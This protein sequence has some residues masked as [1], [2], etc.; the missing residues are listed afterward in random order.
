M[1]W[2]RTRALGAAILVG[3]A[4][5]F[6]LSW[7]KVIIVLSLCLSSGALQHTVSLNFFFELR[8][9]GPDFR[10]ARTKPAIPIWSVQNADCRLQTADC[11]LQTGYKMQ[12]RLKMQT[13]DWVQNADW[14]F[15]LFFRLIRDNISSYN[16]PSVTQCFSATIFHYYLYYCGIFLACFFITIVLNIISSFH[17]VFSLCTRVGWCDVCTEFTKLIKVVADVNWI[18]IT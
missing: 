10:L 15:I 17:A 7:Y 9:F 3:H 13:A 5:A 1:L 11:R 14:E 16:W 4:S 12:T 2:S 6:V 18:F 8:Y